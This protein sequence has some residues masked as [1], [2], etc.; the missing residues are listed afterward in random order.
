MPSWDPQQY[1]GFNDE[2]T[3]PCRDLA[4]RIM[5]KSP[6]RI[7]DL[8][9]GPGNSTQV[10]RERWPEAKTQ[11]LD[12]STEMIA[13]AKK[14]FPGDE[15]QTADIATW[16]AAEPYDLVFSN[17][18]LQW[19]P[20][21][22][23]LYPRLLKQVA[24]GG[25]LAVQVPAN[26]NA[27]AHKRMRE[28]AASPN[29]RQH[30]PGEVREWFVH[31]PA[32]YFDWLVPLS[33][34]VDLWTTEYL[35]VLP[36]PQGIVEWYKGTGLRPFLDQLSSSADRERFLRD[37][38]ELVAMDYPAQANGQVLFPFRRLFLVAYC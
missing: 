19:V 16:S 37:Y 33:Q 22:A 15:W 34:R 7:V 20:D 29:W 36:G 27:P 14:D 13:K 31:E 21:H 30:F 9:C 35:H 1:L 28:L 10:L 8:G 6:A 26:I 2:R 23:V 25:A 4:A 38:L 32:A 24:S 12:S 5:L 3:Q 17:A 18:A 11:G